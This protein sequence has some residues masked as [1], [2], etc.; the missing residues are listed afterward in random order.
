[1]MDLSERPFYI[2][3]TPSSM[4]DIERQARSIKNLALIVVDH[5]GLV[6]S[7]TSGSRYEIM[8]DTAHRLK[9]LALSLQIP[10][11]ALCQ[12]NRQ[13]L[14]R[15]GKRPTMADLR[16]S[17]AI[18]EDS[19]VVCLLFREAEYRPKDKQPKPWE[20]QTVDFIVDKNRHGMTGIVRLDYC[21][22]NAR[23]LE[24][25]DAKRD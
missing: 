10:I 8:T 11:I 9:Q 18:E 3:D 6:K 15:D 4:E 22:M 13:S 20:L 21:P 14:Q 24:G 12:L 25:T 17:G 23:I 2:C 16:D 7:K 5:I 1:M 19:D